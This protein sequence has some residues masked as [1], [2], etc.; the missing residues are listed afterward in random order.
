MFDSKRYL[1]TDMKNRDSLPALK[2]GA[3]NCLF[4]VILQRHSENIFVAKRDIDKQKISPTS[5]A[6][7]HYISQNLTNFDP[8][9]ADSMHGAWRS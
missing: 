1:I 8:Q 6:K 7:E 3:E 5:T 9:M 2:R 4:L